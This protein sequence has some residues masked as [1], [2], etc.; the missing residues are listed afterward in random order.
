MEVGAVE[1]ERLAA[2]QAGDDLEAL[3][4]QLRPR[5]PVAFLAERLETRFDGAEPDGQDHPSG[6][7]P[8]DGCDLTGQLPRTAA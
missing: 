6:T 2:P 3:V 1:L 5:A 4:H 7:Q 8:I